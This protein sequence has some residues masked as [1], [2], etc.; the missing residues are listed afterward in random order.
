M[1]RNIEVE[2]KEVLAASESLS[3][4]EEADSD[5]ADHRGLIS[6]VYRLSPHFNGHT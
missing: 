1:M 6:H 3:D 2:E 5:E 4:E